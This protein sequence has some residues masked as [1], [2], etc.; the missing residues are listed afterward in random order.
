MRQSLI[1][2][3][4]LHA[5]ACSG[6]A[7]TSLTAPTASASHVVASTAEAAQSV[8]GVPFKGDLK[9]TETLDSDLHHLSGGGNGTHLGRFTY[10]ATIAIDDSTGDGTGTVVWTAADGDQVFASTHGSIV[11]ESETSITLRET[12]TITGGTGRFTGAAGTVI[13]TRALDF[14][15]GTTIGSYEGTIGLAH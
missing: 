8:S 14:A 15:T 7:S 1:S 10:T 5:T 3:L 2:L 9:A 6:S 4:T 12:Q 11:N 13:V